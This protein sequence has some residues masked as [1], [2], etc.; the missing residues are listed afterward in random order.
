M[1]QFSLLTLLLCFSLSIKAQIA[2]KT[3]TLELFS[4]FNQNYQKQSQQNTSSK[5]VS[6]ST[7]I[8]PSLGYFLTDDWMVAG[9][10]NW[11]ARW[12]RGSSSSTF[13]NHTFSS[14]DLNLGLNA[15]TRYYIR[16]DSINGVFVFL[17]GQYSSDIINQQKFNDNKTKNPLTSYWE[18]QTGIGLHRFI[19]KNVA[20]ESA[21]F[22]AKSKYQQQL[23]MAIYLKNFFES[24]DKK[25]QDAPP[26]YIAKN[27]L[28]IDGNVAFDYIFTNKSAS[29]N[30][31]GLCGKFVTDR[32]MLGGN[33]STGAYAIKSII[34]N[35]DSVTVKG[36][37][38]LGAFTRY[39]IPLSS[40][41]FIYPYVAANFSYNSLESSFNTDYGLG[42]AYFLTKNIALSGTGR[43]KPKFSS[44]DSPETKE[45]TNSAYINCGIAYYIK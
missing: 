2:P 26:Q 30:L 10:F 40:R 36:H 44:S 19:D 21:L 27:R 25:S 16:N 7:N 13:S 41:L 12:E 3:Q 33:F 4:F 37:L 9:G 45:L 5:G 24:T 1:K 43:L 17:N 18:W 28:L 23:R 38:Y 34:N 8:N 11:G 14:V 39:Y 15:A 22:Y 31:S 35:Q 32:F 6:T 29:L 20:A 42:Y